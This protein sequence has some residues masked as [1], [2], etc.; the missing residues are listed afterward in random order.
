LLITSVPAMAA[1]QS[2]D[3]PPNFVILLIDD[4]GWADVACNGGDLHETPHV[5]RMAR[6]G[7]RFTDAYAAAPIC[8]PTRA[9]LMTGKHPARLHMTIWYEGALRAVR[10]R[11]LVPPT[12]VANLPLAEHTLAEALS[13]A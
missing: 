13:S 2:K 5:D 9:A 12:T 10:D 4:L 6:E 1:E 8:S 3:R 11:K 7:I